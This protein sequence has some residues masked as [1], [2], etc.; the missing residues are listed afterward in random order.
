MREYKRKETAIR[1][2]K[3]EEDFRNESFRKFWC[4]R[5]VYT[6]SLVKRPERSSFVFRHNPG[7]KW[8]AEYMAALFKRILGENRSPRYIGSIGPYLPPEITESK[9]IALQ[10]AHLCDGD[11]SCYFAPDLALDEDV[12]RAYSLRFHKHTE[13][14][15]PYT[16]SLLQD[17]REMTS[18]LISKCPE[19]Y[20]HAPIEMQRTREF[21]IA[22][23][24]HLDNFKYAFGGLHDDEEFV[25]E[26][27]RLCID[28][29]EF[30]EAFTTAS[31][32]IR[33]AC[34]GHDPLE[35]L[36]KSVAAKKLSESLW[37]KSPNQKQHTK[38]I[39]V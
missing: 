6:E 2:I 5:D 1:H 31:Y 29:G 24:A 33:K 7:L 20:W 17:L 14:L 12:Q 18:E 35:Y 38:R 15:S 19:L 25:L 8:H 28:K 36:E 11:Y 39:K 22:I 30:S 23:C 27:L 32:R 26:V 13:A 9:E 10:A 16:Q 21:C 37:Q 4:D 3:K 34:V